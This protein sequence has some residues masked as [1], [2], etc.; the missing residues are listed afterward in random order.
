MADGGTGWITKSKQQLDRQP[1]QLGDYGRTRALN[2]PLQ[3][4][5]SVSEINNSR[6][7]I[8]AAVKMY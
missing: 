5:H 4:E 3:V 8:K 2:V 1:E 6:H 7:I